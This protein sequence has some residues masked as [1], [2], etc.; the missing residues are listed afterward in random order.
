M[1]L[2]SR[3][4]NRLRNKSTSGESGRLMSDLAAS[5]SPDRS[6]LTAAGLDGDLLRLGPLRLGEG[7]THDTVLEGSLRLARIDLKW[8]RHRVA[9]CPGSLSAALGT[10]P[11]R[12]NV[13][14]V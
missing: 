9:F 14:W 3:F 6:L 13:F 11:E 2:A 8:Q 7:D 5:S 4:F 12:V 10:E 1:W